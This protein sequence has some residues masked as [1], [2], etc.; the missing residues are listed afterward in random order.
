M[1]KK[2]ENSGTSWDF[3]GRLNKFLGKGRLGAKHNDRELATLYPVT[4]QTLELGKVTSEEKSRQ[5]Y[6]L[7][8]SKVSG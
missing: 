8:D 1:P 7:L 2:S 3:M 5:Y 4:C 6:A